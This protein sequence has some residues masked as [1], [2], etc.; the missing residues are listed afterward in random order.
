MILCEKESSDRAAFVRK[1]Y[2]RVQKMQSTLSSYPCQEWGVRWTM[3]S[4]S[5]LESPF[6]I[7]VE[8]RTIV[9]RV[10]CY[11]ICG[12]KEQYRWDCICLVS[13]VNPDQ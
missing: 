4:F 12:E 9:A 5:V 6:W 13:V 3:M 1:I 2:I 7:L 11:I 10:D 8:R